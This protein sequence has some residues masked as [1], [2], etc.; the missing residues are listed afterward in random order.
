MQSF[1]IACLA[2]TA[3]SAY[4]TESESPILSLS[5]TKGHGGK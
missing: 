5:Q 3:V 4:Q 2:A 1:A